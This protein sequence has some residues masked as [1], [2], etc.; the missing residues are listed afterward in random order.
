MGKNAVF[1]SCGSCHL[2]NCHLGKCTFGKLPLG[3]LHIWEVATWEIV[4]WEVALGKRPLGKYITPC[5]I[6]KNYLDLYEVVRYPC[7]KCAYAATTVSN[8]KHHMESQHE[9]KNL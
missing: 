5:F 6:I 4:T 8:L 1:P 2:G 3:K 7:K 9:S